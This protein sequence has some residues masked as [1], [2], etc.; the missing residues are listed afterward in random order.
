M[1][2]FLFTINEPRKNFQFWN[3]NYS[4]SHWT[5]VQL[6]VQ[7]TFLLEAVQFFHTTLKHLRKCTTLLTLKKFQELLFVLFLTGRW[8]IYN[9]YHSSESSFNATKTGHT[10]F[11]FYIPVK[12]FV[13]NT[14]KQKTLQISRWFAFGIR[15]RLNFAL[16][17]S[18]FSWV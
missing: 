15:W 2:G 6:A 4:N 18:E 1:S 17:S 5:L 9:F 7:K 11:P 3:M 12:D 10:W 16:V 13:L 8:N 14:C